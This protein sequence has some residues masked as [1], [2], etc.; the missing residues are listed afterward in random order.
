MKSIGLVINARLSSTRCP[1]KH[2]RSMGNKTMIDICLEK[3][4]RLKGL[5]EK[6][7]AVYDKE[8]AERVINYKTIDVLWRQ[9]DAVERGNVKFEI[10]FRHYKE[11]NTKYIMIF[12]PCQPLVDFKVYQD[13]VYWF[14]KCDFDGAISV[15]KKR[16]FFFTDDGVPI[17]FKEGDPLSTQ[18]SPPILVST[19]SFSFFEKEFFVKTGRLWPNKTNNPFPYIIPNDG[20]IDVDTEEDFKICSALAK[21]K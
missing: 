21:I 1:R 9:K 13:A 5:D 11:I 7:L 8:L 18:I 10:A 15:N 3:V 4:D 17:N 20:L 2:L 19:F 12:N 6:K 16:G 14:H